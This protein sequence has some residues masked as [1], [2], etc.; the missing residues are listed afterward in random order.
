MKLLLPEI[1]RLL[2]TTLAT[3]ANVKQK[4]LAHSV[5]DTVWLKTLTAALKTDAITHCTPCYVALRP[6]V[7]SS[8]TH[9]DG[10]GQQTIQTYAHKSSTVTAIGTAL[11]QTY[12][13]T[14]QNLRHDGHTSTVNSVQRIHT[15][16]T[17]S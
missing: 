10:L 16:A 2:S 11:I 4:K 17:P 12:I 9:F 15:V 6:L 3:Y 7:S 8:A 14:C 1:T 5:T 13:P